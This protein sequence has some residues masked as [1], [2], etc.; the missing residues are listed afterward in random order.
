[1]DAVERD[2]GI[3]RSMTRERFKQTP[4]ERVAYGLRFAQMV[5][6]THKAN[7]VP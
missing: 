5:V 1:M 6:D 4:D 7:A 3:D 2:A